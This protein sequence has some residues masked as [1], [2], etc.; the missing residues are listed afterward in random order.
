MDYKVCIVNIA[1]SIIMILKENRVCSY[2]EI[3]NQV[4]KIHG[5]ES[6]YEY[7][8]ALNFLFLLGKIEYFLENDAL[9]LV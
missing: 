5:E 6:K 2:L 8:N 9:E 4:K 1:A 3:L 7:Q